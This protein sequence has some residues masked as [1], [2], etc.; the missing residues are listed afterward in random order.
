MQS[1]KTYKNESELPHPNKPNSPT[2]CQSQI[3]QYGGRTLAKQ[4]LVHICRLAVGE[5]ALVQDVLMD[6]MS[7]GSH[8]GTLDCS[9]T[10]SRALDFLLWSLVHVPPEALEHQKFPGFGGSFINRHTN[11]CFS[12]SELCQWFPWCK[13]QIFFPWW[14]LAVLALPWLLIS[15]VFWFTENRNPRLGSTRFLPPPLPES[16]FLLIQ[17]IQLTPPSIYQPP[18]QTSTKTYFPEFHSLKKGSL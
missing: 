15:F 18:I 1:V 14:G 9:L 5:Q 7:P 8:W 10:A 2:P 17:T 11:R 3:K 16:L 12:L 6:R 4:K 13:R